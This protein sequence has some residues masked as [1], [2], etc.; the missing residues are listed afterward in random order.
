MMS[1]FVCASVIVN[2][3]DNESVTFLHKFTS[4]TWLYLLYGYRHLRQRAFFEPIKDVDRKTSVDSF[5]QSNRR[6]SRLCF[7]LN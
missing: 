3:N 6:R 4:T 7:S 5:E 1:Q 2:D